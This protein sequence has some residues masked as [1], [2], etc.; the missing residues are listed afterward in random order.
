MFKTIGKMKTEGQRGFTLIELLIVIAIIG[1]L[2]AIAAPNYLAYRERAANAA[3]KAEA[4]NFITT[5]IAEVAGTGSEAT[6]H[7]ARLPAGF[8]H[9]TDV[10]IRGVL[11]ID[12]NG[13]ITGHDITFKHRNGSTTYGI[14]EN[15]AVH[16]ETQT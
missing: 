4:S 5:A 9:N 7:V 3:A 11:V 15:G 14:D 8:T 6:F 10:T 1:I 13:T 16:E 2:M 12:A